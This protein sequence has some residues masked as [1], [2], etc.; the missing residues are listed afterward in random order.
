M[1]F[2]T[3]DG[4]EDTIM[5]IDKTMFI[6]GSVIGVIVLAVVGFIIFKGKK[7]KG[8]GGM[9]MSPMGPP[10][11][12]PM[13]SA[14]GPMYGSGPGKFISNN[15]GPIMVALGLGAAA[16]W[17]SSMSGSPHRY[18]SH[19]AQ[20]PAVFA[21]SDK[22]VDARYTRNLALANDR[23]SCSSCKNNYVGSPL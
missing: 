5:G 14:Y 6:I 1:A 23:Y 2:W 3:S 8:A 19:A 9:G 18:Y 21:G 17:L 7:G 4:D 22:Y 16:Y 11:P 10:L 13:P 20:Y 12:P 15:R